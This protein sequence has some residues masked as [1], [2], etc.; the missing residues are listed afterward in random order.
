MLTRLKRVPWFVWAIVGGVV[1][2]GI[3]AVALFVPPFSLVERLSTRDFVQLDASHPAYLHPDGMTVSLAPDTPSL[4]VR[5]SAIPRELFMVDQAGEEWIKARAALPPDLTILSPIYTIETRGQGRIQA[6]MS[7]PNGAEPLSL[8]DLYRWDPLLEEW[9]FMPSRQDR[10]NEGITFEPVAARVH[11]VAAHVAPAMPQVGLVFSP[12]APE[13]TV[14]YNIAMPEGVFMDANGMLTGSPVVANMAAGAAVAPLVTNRPGGFAAYADPALQAQGVEALVGLSVNYDGLVLDFDAS[15]GYTEFVQALAQRLHEGGKTLGVDRIWLEPSQNPLDYLVSGNV[16]ETVGELISRVDRHKVGML[17][18]GLN[19]DIVGEVATPVTLEQAFET[20]GDVEP[21]AGYYD[22]NQP[23]TP[24]LQLAMR[25]TGSI[26]SMSYDTQLGTNYITYR[27]AGGNLHHLYFSSA[28]SLANKLIWARYYGLGAVA[29]Y[30][31]AHPDAPISL[32]DG[33]TAFLNQ[34]SV[35]DPEPLQIVW[36][37]RDSSG[38][39]LSETPGDLSLIQYLWTV[40]ADPGQYEVGASVAGQSTVNDRGVI[41]V[42]VVE[43]PPDIPTPT[44]TPIAS[45]ITG[46]EDLEGTPAA[47]PTA[48]P[49]SAIA[50]GMF[51]LGGQTHSLGHPAEMQRAGMTW[52]KFQHK[53]GSGDDPSGAVGG[54]INQAHSMGFKVLLS[55]PG[56]EHPDT[57]DFQRYISFL[58]GVAALGP[59]AI[60]VWNEQNL[61]REWPTGQINGQA[62]VESMLRPAY[63]AIKAANP[64]VMVISGAPAPTGYW[65]SCAPEGCDDWVY[66]GQMRDAGATNYLDCV[67]IHYNEGIIPPSQTSGDPRGAH[68]TRYFYGMLDLYYGTFG[69]PLCFT[70]LGYLSPEGYP[71]LPAGFS[72]AAETS[73][74]EH[75]AWLAEAAVLS[76]QSGKVRLM[77]IFNVDFTVYDGSDPQAGYAMIRPGGGC[78]ACEALAAVQP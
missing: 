58:T 19:V 60:E 47:A 22:P 3:I 65:G 53:W 5:I 21:I 8:L 61:N 37:V 54:R 50:A 48:A 64:N 62:Y 31:L 11:V 72:W 7:I 23:L 74:A 59:D 13:P 35:G 10:A 51:E 36:R 38:A 32:G 15:A 67:G 66:I 56:G 2:L 39:I 24:G 41:T 43:A 27:D 55:I 70:E 14:V 30:G 78:P 17:V 6:A 9:V 45:P 4:S 63:E 40:V 76:S 34:A 18:N 69:K 29:V 12:D 46:E 42:E 16:R 75:A 26:E 49:P 68:Y 20:F 52:V 73:V 25:L 71:P 1:A 44:P 57:I 28:Y 77:I 33:L